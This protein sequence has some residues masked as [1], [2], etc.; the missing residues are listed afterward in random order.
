[1]SS[2]PKRLLDDPSVPEGLRRTLE[3]AASH[4]PPIDV[5]SGLSR[6]EQTIQ[7]GGGAGG[8]GLGGSSAVGGAIGATLV[9]LAVIGGWM[10]W[11]GE[12]ASEPDAAPDV[13]VV[14]P[15]EAIPAPEPVRAPEPASVDVVDHA[16]E[17]ATETPTPTAEPRTERPTRAE[18]A[19]AATPPARDDD[20]LA[21][22]MAALAAARTALD[23]DPGRALS[24]LEQG[25]REHGAASL[26]AEE[27]E[28]LTVLALA[29]LDRSAEARRRGERFLRAHPSSAFAERVRRVLDGLAD[30]RAAS[31][32]R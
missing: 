6:L 8:G 27:R 12:P 17:P 32:S 3:Q 30:P 19:A 4:A 5:A 20:A 21:R 18:R 25:R 14:A 10:A 31:P 26:F 9:V 22:E 28:A 15:P 13:P 11:S 2:D 1:L 29:A 7:S 23:H 16:P 24:L